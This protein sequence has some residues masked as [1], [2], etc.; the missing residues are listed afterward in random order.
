[1]ALQTTGSVLTGNI[2]VMTP[3]QSVYGYTIARG[4]GDNQMIGNRIR[5]TSLVHDFT[6]Y[7]T[8]YNV[9]TNTQCRPSIVRL[10]Y[11]KVKQF[12]AQD[13]DVNYY[14]NYTTSAASNFFDFSSNDA[15]FVG[16]LFDITRK[17]APE[18]Y[19]YIT[20]RTYKVGQSVPPVTSG[21]S[22]DHIYSNN[23]YKMSI[24]GRVNL[25]KHVHANYTKNDANQWTKPWLFCLIQVVAG[26]GD[27][28]ATT[29][30]PICV[31]SNISCVYTDD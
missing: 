24:I 22:G 31:Q 1:M 10:Y 29:Q 27:I 30:L 11:F 14:A 20:H 9:T 17:I 19:T 15:G 12:P 2:A 18:N 25:S 21:T 28:Y 7:P 23:D 26:N 5:I 8:P 3:S 4:S 16:G 6:I 13:Q